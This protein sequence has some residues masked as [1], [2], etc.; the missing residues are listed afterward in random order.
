M[1][2]KSGPK[3]L[4]GIGVVAFG[5]G[6][7]ILLFGTL[8][9]SGA[10]FEGFKR[11]A[12][13]VFWLIVGLILLIKGSFIKTVTSL[14][15]VII[16]PKCATAYNSQDVTD[17]ICPTCKIELEELDGFYKRHPEWVDRSNVDELKR[18]IGLKE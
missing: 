15:T 10:R 12:Y 8:P 9:E 7:A 11:Y 17:G 6:L 5:S 13:G 18:K 16:C 4:V 3:I 1:G 14:D 2:K